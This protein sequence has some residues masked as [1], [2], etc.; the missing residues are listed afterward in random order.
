MNQSSDLIRRLVA[1]LID[2]QKTYTSLAFDKEECGTAR[3]AATPDQIAELER[4]FGRALPS[5]VK[6]FLH[7]HNGFERF[8][9]DGILFGTE[10]HDKPWV[11]KRISEF[12]RNWQDVDPNP[13]YHGAAPLMM[14]PDIQHFVVI[15]QD[16]VNQNG[17][18]LLVEYD[19]NAEVRT[20]PDIYAFFENELA[21]L[22]GMID[23]QRY[24]DEI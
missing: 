11:A 20:F 5:S 13:F 8:H 7:V 3:P 19:L 16:R 4:K 10:D 1:D 9:A 23:R 14:G 24:G 18:P 12:N 17:E 21:T 15:A 22:K 2:A 6:S